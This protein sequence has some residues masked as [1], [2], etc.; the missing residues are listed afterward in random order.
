[1]GLVTYSVSQVGF[2]S[3]G[4]V[5]VCAQRR[6]RGRGPVGG[7]AVIDDGV[8]AHHQ[9]LGPGLFTSTSSGLDLSA[10]QFTMC[11]SDGPNS[12]VY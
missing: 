2:S 5:G 4:F 12:G 7:L 11:T 1:M 3:M 6:A 8:G 10:I 9:L